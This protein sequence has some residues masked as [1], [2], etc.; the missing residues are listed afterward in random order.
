MAC[1]APCDLGWVIWELNGFNGR[2]MGFSVRK[3]LG[4]PKTEVQVERKMNA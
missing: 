4:L 2:G 1:D 3:G